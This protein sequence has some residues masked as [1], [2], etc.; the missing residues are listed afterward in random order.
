M[1]LF[2]V[3]LPTTVFFKNDKNTK[4]IHK[5]THT[6][7]PPTNLAQTNNLTP[8]KPV[9]NLLFVYIVS[10]NTNASYDTKLNKYTSTELADRYSTSAVRCERV[11]K[12]LRAALSYTHFHHSDGIFYNTATVATATTVVQAIIFGNGTEGTHACYASK[13]SLRF[14]TQT[15]PLHLILTCSRGSTFPRLEKPT[16]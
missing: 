3:R 14:R 1:N 9:G 15:I 11:C 4:H 2:F 8:W 7:T 5:H 12:R 10:N 16:P 6:Y 13:P